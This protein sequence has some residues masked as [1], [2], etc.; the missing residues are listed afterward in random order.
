MKLALK[1][2]HFQIPFSI[3]A[4]AAELSR[5]STRVMMQWDGGTG[6]WGGGSKQSNPRVVT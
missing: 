4:A 3:M 2:R 5:I 1:D 6:D